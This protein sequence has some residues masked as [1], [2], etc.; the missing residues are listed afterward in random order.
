L[1]FQ[2]TL[3]LGPLEKQV[4]FTYSGTPVV[5]GGRFVFK[6]GGGWIGKLPLHPSLLSSTGL[7]S[8]YFGQIFSKLDHERDILSRLSAITITPKKAVL[9][10]PSAGAQ[11]K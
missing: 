1:T 3:N 2:G 4:A 7:M 9:N 8:G 10:Y 6:P 11:K 5:G